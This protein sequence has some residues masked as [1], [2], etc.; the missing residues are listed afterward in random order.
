MFNSAYSVV[1]PTYNRAATLGRAINSVLAQ[2][3]PPAEIIVVDDASTDATDD[4]LAALGVRQLRVVRQTQNRGAAA[5]RNV[6]ARAASASWIAFLDSD[7]EWCTEKAERQ[8]AALAAGTGAAPARGSVTGYKIIDSRNSQI[9]V[10]R[11]T[12]ADVSFDAVLFG[13]RL[14]PGSTLVVARDTFLADG[15]LDTLLPRLEDWDW[16]LRYLQRNRL[17]AVAEPLVVVHKSSNP[18][19]GDVSTS[20]ARIRASHRA[21]IY[22]R[23]WLQG[24]KFDAALFAEAAAGALYDKD[25]AAAI[26]LTLRAFAAY[27]LREGAFFGTLGRRVW[28]LATR[29]P[30]SG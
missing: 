12:D 14:S 30:A 20:L 26:I 13:C 8:M 21:G 19:R 28:S 24:R 5:A 1:I 9:G 25:H 11:P 15:G 4:V 3:L 22:E 2:S 6:G 17:A 18:S 29:A 27:P 10:F 7:D 16:A 23:S